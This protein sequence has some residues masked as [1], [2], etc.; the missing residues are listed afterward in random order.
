MGL[1]AGALLLITDDLRLADPL[2]AARALPHG[3]LIILRSRDAKRRATLARQLRPIARK[4]GLILLIA[5]DPALAR[6]VGAAGLHLPAVRAHEVGHWRARHPH[7]LITA[8]AHSLEAVLAARH[9]D[10]VLLSPVFGTQ[11]HIGAAALSPARARLMALASPVPLFALGGV[12][13][14]NAGLLF[15]FAGIAAIGALTL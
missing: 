8:S 13:A 10:A 15:G 9:A 14:K 6:A 1:N 12:T 3:S 7:W 2:A 4:R 11:S 5:D